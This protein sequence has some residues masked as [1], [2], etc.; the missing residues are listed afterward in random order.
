MSD[1][2]K[3]IVM[4]QPVDGRNAA[5]ADEF[6]VQQSI[7]PALT[8]E[9][10]ARLRRYNDPASFACIILEGGYDA[11]LGIDPNSSDFAKDEAAR[12]DAAMA[13][14]NN[15]LPDD[16]PRKITRADVR[17]LL[18]EWECS[19]ATDDPDAFLRRLAAKLAALLPPE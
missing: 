5:M 16:D 9:L 3:R 8:A 6:V 18:Y 12:A 11:E 7:Q 2:L 14:S 19:S 17:A 1:Q 13:V 15:A 10:W 4:R